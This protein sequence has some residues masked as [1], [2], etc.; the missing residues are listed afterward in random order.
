LPLTLS[1]RESLRMRK[2][3]GDMIGSDAMQLDLTG[4]DKTN[5]MHAI[6]PDAATHD[7]S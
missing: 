5:A 7:E 4:P 2:A 6:G 1:R 3:D